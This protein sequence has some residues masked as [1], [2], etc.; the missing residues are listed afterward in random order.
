MKKA[1]SGRRVVLEHGLISNVLI[2]LGLVDMIMIANICHRT[3]QVT[4]PW[5]KRAIVIP[6][7]PPCEFPKI[8]IPSDEFVFKRMHT[9]IGGEDG[10]YYGCVKRSS[11]LLEGYGVFVACEWVHCG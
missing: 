5:N 2:G 10:V 11:D 6:R 8:I 4:V 7:D 3:H 9:T 1:S